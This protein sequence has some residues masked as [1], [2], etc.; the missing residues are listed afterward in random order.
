MTPSERILWIIQGVVIVCAGGLVLLI[1][2][3]FARRLYRTAKQRYLNAW[4]RV[5]KI[6]AGNAE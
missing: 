2:I 4:V 3:T 6:F 1:G 5:S